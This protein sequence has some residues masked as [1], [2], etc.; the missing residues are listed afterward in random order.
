MRYNVI[1]RNACAGYEWIRLAR[2]CHGDGVVSFL[3]THIRLAGEERAA[4]AE[5]R[6]RS[7]FGNLFGSFRRLTGMTYP[8]KNGTDS[9]AIT[10]RGNA[11]C[12]PNHIGVRVAHTSLIPLV[13]I[14]LATVYRSSTICALGYLPC[15]ELPKILPP[16]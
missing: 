9:D 10:K 11:S 2:E 12:C 4:F 8:S 1:S 5:H 3:N 14:L 15:G 13:Q 6:R 7:R 16:E